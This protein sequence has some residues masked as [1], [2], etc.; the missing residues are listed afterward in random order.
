M[1]IFSASHAAKGEVRLMPF[2]YFLA[3][4][5]GVFIATLVAAVIKTAATR[6]QMCAQLM[7][8]DQPAGDEYKQTPAAM[9]AS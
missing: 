1:G 6:K 5:M 3:A 9:A 7:I 8:Q 4:G 2:V